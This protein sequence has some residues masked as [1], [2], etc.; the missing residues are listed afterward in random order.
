MSEIGDPRA[1]FE[2]DLAVKKRKLKKQN[3]SKLYVWLNFYIYLNRKAKHEDL[4]EIFK[5]VNASYAVET[6]NT[7]V[8]FKCEERYTSMKSAE[9]DLNH[10][11][12]L[13]INSEI[14]GVI[15]AE[16]MNNGTIVNLGPIAIK[17]CQQVVINICYWCAIFPFLRHCH[18][19]LR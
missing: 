17:P 18:S 5:I 1:S 3:T 6:G 8:A 13:K 15:K 10:L 12:V 19:W 16:L 14:V 4:P 11:S 9:R 7:G 2:R